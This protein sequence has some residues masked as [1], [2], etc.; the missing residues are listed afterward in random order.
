AG[1][2]IDTVGGAV[3]GL[4]TVTVTGAEVTTLPD[5]SRATA[6]N[7]RVP[8]PARLE[9][10]VIENGLVVSSAPRFA[11][12]SLNCTPA[13]PTLSDAEAETVMLPVT[14]APFAGA[15]IETVGGVVSSG[16]STTST[17]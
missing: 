9:S 6:V 8:F 17:Q 5:K 12:S 7:T 13:T 3:S 2:V 1:A 10:Q 4:K 16:P 11:P 14:A 15:L